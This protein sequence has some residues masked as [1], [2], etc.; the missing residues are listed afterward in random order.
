MAAGTKRP[1]NEFIA[2]KAKKTKV[3]H[4]PHK[5]QS[6]A[7]KPVQ[8][9]SSLVAEDFDFP[10]GGG[11]S[12]TPLEVKSI[13]AEAVKEANEELF[14]V[15]SIHVVVAH[16]YNVLQENAPKVPQRERRR[17]G[18]KKDKKKAGSDG[19]SEAM[20]R[21]EHLNYKVCGISII[22]LLST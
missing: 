13:R 21:I 16:S 11:S 15:S 19:R 18:A 9:T 10:R 3:D 22:R 12:F 2:P 1:N 20:V 8:S 7:D 17:S 14:K 5:Q 4:K 6:L